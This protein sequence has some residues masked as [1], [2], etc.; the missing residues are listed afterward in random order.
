MASLSK[1]VFS[2]VF[3]KFSERILAQLISFVVSVVIARILSPEDYG[4]VAM[5]MIFITIANVF[6]SNGFSTALIQKKEADYNDFTTLFYCSLFI[7]IIFYFVLFFTAPLI[8][9]FYNKEELVNLVKVFG[10]I[11]PLSSYK[12]IQNAYVSKS[13]DFKKFFFSTLAGTIA[14]GIVGI[15]MA[16]KGFGVWA[17]VAQYFTNNIIDAIVLTF[18]IKWK[19]KFFFSFSKAKPLLSYGSRILLVD[20]IGTIYNQLTAFIIGKQYSSTDLAF[21]TKGKQLPDLINTNISST[22]TSVLFPAFSTSSDDYTEIKNMGRKAI[23]TSGYIL[24]PFFFGLMAVSHNLINFLLTEKWLPCVI[25]VNIMCVNGIINTLD[26]ID[27]QVLKAI[28]KSNTVLKLE[29]IKKPIYLIVIFISMKINVYALA[30][31]VPITSVIAI[32]ANSHYIKKYIGYTLFEK[33]KDTGLSLLFSII[34]YLSVFALGYIKI[35]TNILLFIQII[36]GIIVY[37]SL[38]VI[39]KNE[40]M[41]YI[42]SVLKKQ[43]QNDVPSEIDK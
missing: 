23:K 35:N 2:G 27:I 39:T 5:V 20:L 41:N 26:M 36:T 7:S 37:I 14:S 31:S 12:S 43:K 32:I 3:W 42:I 38:S 8:A 11:L 24:L 33:I 40:T 13:L 1:K 4:L 29:F 21:Y 34:M 10:L 17:L 15:I 25:F 19:P 30:I 18:T 9:R 22:I 6:V 28:G 16:V